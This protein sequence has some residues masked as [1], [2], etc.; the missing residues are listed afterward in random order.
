MN[1]RIVITD[2]EFELLGGWE[3]CKL[4]KNPDAKFVPRIIRCQTNDNAFRDDRDGECRADL[5]PIELTK[6]TNTE[7]NLT[8]HIYKGPDGKIVKEPAGQIW[9]GNMSRLPLADWRDFAKVLEVTPSNVAYGVGAMREDLPDKATIV[10]KNDEKN[11][12]NGSA[13]RTQGN[14]IYLRDKPA[15]VLCDFDTDEMPSSVKM[16]LDECG[17]FAAALEKICPAFANTAYITRA[18]TSANITDTETGATYNSL[19]QHLFLVVKNGNDAERCLKTL[20]ERAWLCGF[21]WCIITKCGSIAIRS[22]ID[23]SVYAPERLV[24]EGA[25]VC[26]PPLRQE[27][28]AAVIHDGDAINTVAECLELSNFE[29]ARFE[30]VITNTKMALANE[31]KN[32]RDAWYEAH[33]N[34][35]VKR[36]VPR[37]KA[38]AQTSDL[39]N[40]ILGPD[41]E[42]EFDSR[43]IG[44]VVVADVLADPKRYHLETL[45]D[46]VDGFDIRGRNRAKLYINDDGAVIVHAYTEF[47]EVNYRLTNGKYEPQCYG[48]TTLENSVALQFVERYGHKVRYV[49][50]WNRY[51]IWNG[52]HW[53]HDQT[54]KVFNRI[55]NMVC[56]AEKKMNAKAKE[57][58]E[59]RKI[60]IVKAKL[61]RE[62]EYLV[63][64]ND[65]I[66]ATIHQ[67]DKDPWMLN[68]PDGIVDLRT[69]VMRSAK[70]EDY[71]LK[72]TSV[73][74]ASPGTPCPKFEAVVLTS[75]N[76]REVLVR[77]LQRT[78]G[79]SITG[80]IAEHAFV[81]H[82]S[83]GANGKGALMNTAS[84][85]LGEYAKTAASDT[86][87]VSHNPKHLTFVASLQGARLVTVP[88]T[89]KG[90]QLNEA[91]IKQLTGGDPVQANFMRCDP[92]EFT[93][94]F[95]LHISGNNKLRLK[96]VGE[97]IRRRLNL[98]PYDFIVPL[99]NRDKY[100]VDKL[101]NEEG[102]AILRWMID[103]CL[104]WQRD[105]LA[106]PEAITTATEEYLKSEDTIGRWIDDCCEK[107]ANAF[108]SIDELWKSICH[109]AEGETAPSKRQL[110]IELGR[111]KFKES[112]QRVMR[113]G[114]AGMEEKRSRGFFGL[115]LLS[116]DRVF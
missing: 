76:Q 32:V 18:S 4:I 66:A 89:E 17:G 98:V 56:Y 105:G 100:L 31:A 79:Y 80:I 86:F 33:I 73:G 22:I 61:V 15:F 23:V 21:G 35:M 58:G 77:Y 102:P 60:K 59:N 114:A 112:I 14:I 50:V 9:R 115:R 27:P 8:K 71:C 101:V 111:R 109:W 41:V 74:P 55:Y 94:V 81:F 19:G 43:E 7:G 96:S 49:K 53:E 38:M 97:A 104:M 12:A 64:I 24:Y 85:L 99:E 84:R 34:E 92:F 29:K 69:G 63:R 46:P 51:F 107:D 72:I 39:E 47:G 45:A 10:L 68:T 88:E 106:P 113:P 48:E 2:E 70:P 6:F 67:W 11:S 108:S 44:V 54:G 42:L 93:P 5:V 40:K 75:M 16:R 3:F 28:R 110:S 13:A 82:F 26:D 78:F 116:Y 30:N 37:D 62:I 90:K 95:K 65:R 57:R 103:G 87:T 1:E 91:L 20:Q 52:T 83:E 36:G 25:A